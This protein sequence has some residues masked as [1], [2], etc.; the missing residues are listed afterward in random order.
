[1]NVLF[2]LQSA[3]TLNITYESQL[4]ANNPG[5]TPALKGPE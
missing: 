3:S 5:S 1:M 4:P 2:E